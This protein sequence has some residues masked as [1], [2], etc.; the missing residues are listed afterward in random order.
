[1]TPFILY[2]FISWLI[3]IGIGTNPEEEFRFDFITIFAIM[4][5]P[6][7]IPMYLGYKLSKI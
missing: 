1:M 6:L 7:T 5:A 2:C 4:T 3:A